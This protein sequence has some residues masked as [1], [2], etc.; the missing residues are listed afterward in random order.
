MIRNGREPAVMECPCSGKTVHDCK[1]VDVPGARLS[2]GTPEA[3][4]GPGPAVG[5]P[6]G[7]CP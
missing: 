1:T 5:E 7:R 3:V 6:L 2:R 4:A